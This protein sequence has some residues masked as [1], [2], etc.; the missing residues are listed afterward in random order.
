MTSVERLA[1]RGL[2]LDRNGELVA[3]VKPALVITAIPAAVKRNPWVIEKIASLLGASPAK[4][5]DKVKD[6]EWR[7]YL[8]ASIYVGAPIEIATR[9]A[10]SGDHLPGIGVESEPIRLYPDTRS[11]THLLGYV[12]IP[13]GKDVERLKQQ[14]IDPAPYVGKDGIE[15]SFERDLTGVPGREVLEVDARRRPLRVIERDNAIPGAKLMLSIDSRLQRLA[16]ELLGDRRGAAVA[17]EPGTG[18]V[19]CLVSSPTYDLTPFLGGISK[20]AWEA[21][22]QDEDRPLI[23]RAISS[24]Y[25]PGSTFKIVTTLA[26]AKAGVFSAARAGYCPGFYMVGRRR[27]G[28]LGEHGSIGYQSAISRSCNAFFC[29][30]AFRSGVDALRGQAL[31]AGLGARTGID[32]PGESKGVIP[33]EAW[34]AGFDP[35]R[36]W[37]PGDTVNL[38][39][40]QGQ[41]AV[42]PLQMAC[43]IS[44]VANSGVSYRPRLVRAKWSFGD[45]LGFER[46]PTEELVR[47][48]APSEVWHAL[49]EGLRTVIASGTASTAARIPG[50]DWA[51]KTGSAEHARRELTHS[52]FVGFAPFDSPRVAVAVLVESAGHGSEVAAPIARD[53]VRAY[54]MRDSSSARVAANASE[55]RAA[56]SALAESPISR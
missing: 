12:W 31:A 10:E 51:G 20:R 42:T 24:A 30:W 28:C 2:I 55:A 16:A 32:I 48:D 5:W 53:I 34:L 4:L 38:G 13:S 33:T 41:V 14:G 25:A 54:L 9:I 40:G 44:L 35:P 8:P 36:R 21:L 3:G 49:R 37:Y 18:E 6:S 27:V 7:P 19:L 15:R 50:L 46:T 29:D 23:N 26:A 11:F 39:I 47:V 56:S 17:I 52:W 22:L 43:L 45:P 1:P